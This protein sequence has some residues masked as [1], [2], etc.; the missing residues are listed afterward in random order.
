MPIGAQEHLVTR[1]PVAA[2]PP[3]TPRLMRDLADCSQ[4]SKQVV[5]TTMRACEWIPDYPCHMGAACALW[6]YVLGYCGA[7]NYLQLRNS[8]SHTRQTPCAGCRQKKPALYIVCR[9]GQYD[10]QRT[11]VQLHSA[12]RKNRMNA[13]IQSAAQSISAVLSVHARARRQR[14]QDR[15]RE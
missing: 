11:I 1:G 13:T 4:A 5:L 15:S 9:L 12:T 2:H 7:R 6:Q 3:L 10:T 14:V 8:K